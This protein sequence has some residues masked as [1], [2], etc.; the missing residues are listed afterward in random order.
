M[1]NIRKFIQKFVIGFLTAFFVVFPS[2][3][4]ASTIGIAGKTATVDGRPIHWKIRQWYGMNRLVFWDNDK[5]DDGLPDQDNDQNGSFDKFAYLG[6]VSDNFLPPNYGKPTMGLNSVGL[7]ISMIII[8]ETGR[9]GNTDPV[10]THPLGHY[11]NTK[12]F[13]SYLQT[14]PGVYDYMNN[15]AEVSAI[16]GMI[17]KNGDGRVY[18]YQ[19]TRSEQIFH[20][21]YIA[22]DPARAEIEKGFAKYIDLQDI[23]CRSN[24]FLHDKKSGE[25]MLDNYPEI[26]DQPKYLA[27]TDS[28]VALKRN[29]TL[30]VLSLLQGE[31]PESEN[32]SNIILRR[33]NIAEP[34]NNCSAMIIHGVKDS[35][36]PRLTTMWV[37]LGHTNYSIAVPVWILGVQ[38]DSKKL[39]PRNLA[40]EAEEENIAGYADKLKLKFSGN[41]FLDIQA[42][43]FPFERHLIETVQNILLPEWRKANMADKNQLRRVGKEMN[44]VQ[45][46]MA[47]EAFNL[48][49]FLY[50]Q[51]GTST[52]ATAP[53]ISISLKSQSGRMVEFEKIV[54]D[55]NG[56]ATAVW[57]F[58]DGC[59]GEENNHTYTE[60][61][62]YLVS[63]SVSNIK[64]ISQTDWLI[65]II[66]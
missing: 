65:I 60:S 14:A 40:S 4:F 18:E 63:Y 12:P 45:N 32:H 44:R 51:A 25:A 41:K 33:S 29:K 62:T 21:E 22:N 53:A 56:I 54:S 3:P 38:N 10:V 37:V 43:T 7:S 34:P 17:D 50:S 8:G 24:F 6:I 57:D 64:N 47:A 66:D 20:R 26:F 28:M 15:T 49:K 13:Y 30:S 48:I 27:A 35:E 58:G 46:K 39:P 1:K 2:L 5:D 16:Y 19:K 55:N 52:F 9:Q 42:I 11:I 36:N 31:H 23:I 59:T 61:G